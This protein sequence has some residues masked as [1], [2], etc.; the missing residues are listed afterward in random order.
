MKQKIIIADVEENTPTANFLNIFVNE[1][2]YLGHK[3]RFIN[4]AAMD[5]HLIFCF[6]SGK[7]K[8]EW[9]LVYVV[10]PLQA[11]TVCI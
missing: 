11:L 4:E 9:Q 5:T 1:Y 3:G 10:I 8:C 2:N 7:V 6:E